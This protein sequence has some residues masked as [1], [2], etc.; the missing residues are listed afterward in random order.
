MTILGQVRIAGD[1][2][3]KGTVR[4]VRT[5]SGQGTQEQAIPF[6]AGRTQCEADSGRTESLQVR[7]GRLWRAGK[8]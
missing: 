8:T 5:G 7:T 6:T 2:L 1:L 4:S 3:A